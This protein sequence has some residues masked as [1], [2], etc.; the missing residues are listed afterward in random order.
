MIH[1]DLFTWYHLPRTGGTATTSWWR[2]VA[3]MTVLD[4]AV[5]LP[6]VSAK[7]DNPATRKLRDVNFI[8]GST[9]LV[10]MKRLPDWLQSNFRFARASGLAVPEERYLKGEF[11]S[12]RTGS[13]CPADW[14][15]DYFDV[16]NIQ[17]LLPTDT[18]EQAWRQFSVGMLGLEV[19]DKLKFAQENQIG[20]D[21]PVSVQ[22]WD[23]DKADMYQRNPI[24]AQQ[25]RRAFG[26]AFK[27]ETTGA[28]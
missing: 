16:E 20:A 1:C 17:V 19:P 6:E 12:L 14:W 21:L 22:W 5:D 11:F 24:W 18:L 4:V 28:D 9:T 23:R 7:H 2:R 25:E 26:E 27:A 10:N 8:D 15:M 3:D 13:W